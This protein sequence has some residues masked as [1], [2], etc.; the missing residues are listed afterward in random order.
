[1]WIEFLKLL[2]YSSVKSNQTALLN[3]IEFQETF[4]LTMLYDFLLFSSIGLKY[5]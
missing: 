5:V 2:P 4:V 1:M 3:Y